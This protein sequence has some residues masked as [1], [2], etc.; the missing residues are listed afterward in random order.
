MSYHLARPR[1]VGLLPLPAPYPL[2]PLAAAEPLPAHI[3]LTPI[4]QPRARLDIKRLLVAI[5]VLILIGAFLL[6]LE[7]QLESE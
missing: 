3:P 6:W 5:V 2:Y 7:R 4:P 1:G